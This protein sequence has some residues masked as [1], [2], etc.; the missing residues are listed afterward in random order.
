MDQE[1]ERFKKQNQHRHIHIDLTNWNKSRKLGL[2]LFTQ[3]S[4]EEEEE[5]RRTNRWA[6]TSRIKPNE[7]LYAYSSQNKSS[8]CFISSSTSWYMS[9][10]FWNMFSNHAMPLEVSILSMNVRRL[11]VI[12]LSNAIEDITSTSHFKN[13]IRLHQCRLMSKIYLIKGTQ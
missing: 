2:A 1:H 6:A 12:Q 11:I 3:K 10:N 4:K 8:T 9:S 5:E 7:N 13:Y